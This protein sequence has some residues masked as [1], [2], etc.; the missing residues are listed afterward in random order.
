ME[1]KLGMIVKSMAGHDSGRFYVIVR[2]EQN[3]IYIADGKRRRLEKPKMKNPIHLSKSNKVI[4]LSKFKT[5]KSLRTL[6][7]N[8]NNF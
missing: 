1:L 5:N 3:K 7:H 4:D 6:L 2:L 8:Y